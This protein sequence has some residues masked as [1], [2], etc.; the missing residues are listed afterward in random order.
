[1]CTRTFVSMTSSQ[2]EMAMRKYLLS[3]AA[4]A[5]LMGTSLAFAQTNETTTTTT[6]NP[7]TTTRTTVTKSTDSNGDYTQYKKTVTSTRHYDAGAWAAPA[8]YSA[9]RFNLGDRLPSDLLQ[10]NYYLTN[11]STYSLAPPPSG[12]VWVRVGNDAFLVRNDDGE[13]IQADY[14]MFL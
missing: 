14:G 11:Y 1:M 4:V 2:M 5:L 13:I 10:D 6:Q 3:S 9:R 8:D 12:T 7:D